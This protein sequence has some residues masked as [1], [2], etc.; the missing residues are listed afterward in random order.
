MK[1]SEKFFSKLI[2]VWLLAALCCLLWGSAFPAIKTGYELFK[3]DTNDTASIILFAGLRFTT[4]GILTIIIF[5]LIDKKP[6]K[7]AK[8]S[9]SKI[10]VLALFQTIFQYAFF[11]L[12]LAKTTGDRASVINATSVFISLLISCLLFKMEKLT[13]SKIIGCIIG[14]SGVVLVSLDIFSGS[15][16]L[17][18]FGELFILLSSISYAFSSVF[19]KR[20]SK[21]ENPAMLS[22]YQFF[23]GGLV[24]VLVGIFSGGRI[25]NFNYKSVF[26]L[27]YLAFVSA[28]AYSLWSIL[29]KYNPVSRVAV[30]GFMTPIFG[31]MLSIIFSNEKSNMGIIGL[32]SLF[33][34]ASGI[35]LVNLKSKNKYDK[36]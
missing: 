14:F 8:K 13:F 19:M 7:P 11:Y 27:I 31:Y 20:Y 26:L 22:G 5:S 1:N 33:L 10:S 35:V 34:V 29:L 6:L 16:D 36:F 18:F 15:S 32:P 24:L 23:A 4:A 30:C 28:I 25:S 9:I 2:V 3:I 17:T 12:G 21:T